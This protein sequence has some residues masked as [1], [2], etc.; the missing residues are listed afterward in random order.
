MD[1]KGSVPERERSTIL[2]GSLPKWPPQPG[3]GQAGA[4]SQELHPGLLCGFQGWKPALGDARVQN[5]QGYGC[6]VGSWSK[7]WLGLYMMLAPYFYHSIS[8]CIVTSGGSAV[9]M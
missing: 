2:L 5:D 6:H 1:L 3:L 9:M 8:D 4:G 7:L